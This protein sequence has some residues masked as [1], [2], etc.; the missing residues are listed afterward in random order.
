MA[1][2]PADLGDHDAKLPVIEAE[3]E[4][5][6]DGPSA[7]YMPEGSGP[8]HSESEM[9]EV[10]TLFESNRHTACRVEQVLITVRSAKCCA[11]TAGAL[12]DQPDAPRPQSSTREPLLTHLL[13]KH[14][15]VG[16]S[17]HTKMVRLAF[18]GIERTKGY[19]VARELEDVRAA[20]TLEEVLEAL[21]GVHSALD[22]LGIFEAV[23]IN[24]DR[25][26][27]VLLLLVA[28]M[29]TLTHSHASPARAVSLFT[30]AFRHAAWQVQ[31]HHELRG[32]GPPAPVRRVLRP[33]QRRCD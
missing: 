27:A 22:S 1:I 24:I 2:P 10:E 8:L 9:H 31:R 12:T 30:C 14:P 13:P 23:E 20:R 26:D 29:F 11:S 3:I 6:P 5:L 4:P 7:E 19:V 15:C 25:G 18:Q 28:H 16:C 17:A 33:G 32:E 21:Q